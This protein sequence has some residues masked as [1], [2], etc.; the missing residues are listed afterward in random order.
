VRVAGLYSVVLFVAVAVVG[1]NVAALA[2][3][4]DFVELSGEGIRLVDHVH[5]GGNVA[6]QVVAVQV[7]SSDQNSVPLA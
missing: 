4:E 5:L 1:G 6:G 2:D 7:G 3:M